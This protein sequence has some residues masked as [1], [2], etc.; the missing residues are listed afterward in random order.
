M[1]IPTGLAKRFWEF[2]VR[3]IGVYQHPDLRPVF[4]E[5]PRFR[6]QV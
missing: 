2:I 6:V 3:R 4:M 5:N 1:Y